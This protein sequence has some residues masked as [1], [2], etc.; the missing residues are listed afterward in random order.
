MYIQQI[1]PATAM[2]TPI[3]VEILIFRQ[4]SRPTF[5]AP[6]LAYPMRY[7]DARTLSYP[8]R[9]STHNSAIIFACSFNFPSSSSPFFEDRHGRST[10]LPVLL[11]SQL[12]HLGIVEAPKPKDSTTDL[13]P[14]STLRRSSQDSMTKFVDLLGGF[15]FVFFSPGFDV[16]HSR[17]PRSCLGQSLLPPRYL[18]NSETF[19][20]CY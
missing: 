2:G 5:L 14:T 10:V 4:S 15:F 1:Q 12:R 11:S 9:H 7:C 19:A 6:V 8:G 17:Y 18:V 3:V 20:H 13:S 16:I